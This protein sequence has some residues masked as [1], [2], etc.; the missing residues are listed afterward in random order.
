MRPS[1]GQQ[2]ALRLEVSPALA[3][4]GVSRY[5]SRQPARSPRA[6][7]GADQKQRPKPVSCPTTWVSPLEMVIVPLI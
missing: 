3:T 1:P 4:C 6:A 7:A 5:G 2:A